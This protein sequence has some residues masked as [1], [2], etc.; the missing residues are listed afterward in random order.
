VLVADDH[1][2]VREPNERHENELNP[3]ERDSITSLILIRGAAP[4][5]D[6]S[7]RRAAPEA[8]MPVPQRS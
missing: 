2:T 5:R 3:L 4:L 6:P 8:R 7:A 1:A